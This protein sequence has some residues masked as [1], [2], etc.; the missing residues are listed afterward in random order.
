MPDYTPKTLKDIVFKN[1]NDA[2][3]LDLISQGRLK[4]PDAGKNG[5]LFYGDYGTGK[6]SAAAMLPDIVESANQHLS[7]PL[8]SIQGCRT[9]PWSMDACGEPK[10]DL[11]KLKTIE[12]GL[13]TVPPFGSFHHTIIDEIDVLSKAHQTRVRNMMA[14]PSSVWYFTTNHVHRVDGGIRNRC[15]IVDFEAAP[16]R[17][18]L[19]LFCRILSDQGALAPSN[20][21]MIQA[22]FN[23]N[24]SARE[25]IQT[26]K[27]TAI[28]QIRA[29]QVLPT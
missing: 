25:I 2:D 12:S 29:G 8:F 6:S 20:Q 18:W 13:Q 21:V 27:E 11:P 7:Q 9:L 4:F 5:V 17:S 14:H 28:A 24:G 19:P 10:R 1:A 23:C 15:I 26:A 3:R 16:P 22:I